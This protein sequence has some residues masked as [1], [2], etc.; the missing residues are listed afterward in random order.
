MISSGHIEISI[1]GALVTNGLLFNSINTKK[2]NGV[3]VVQNIVITTRQQYGLPEDAVIY[4]CFNKLFKISPDL[5]H[6]WVNVRMNIVLFYTISFAYICF[7]V[8]SDI[9]SRTQF[10]FVVVTIPEG[11]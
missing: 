3:A 6:M 1:N 8:H 5:F 9:E 11:R 10:Y 2:G 4:C 7:I